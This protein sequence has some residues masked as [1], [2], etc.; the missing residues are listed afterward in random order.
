MIEKAF[1]E[2]F[3]NREFNYTTQLKYSRQFSAYNA[4]IRSHGKSLEVKMCA[5]W[6]DIGEEI[7]I[8]CIQHLLQ[9][10]FK[11]KQDTFYTKLYS[12]FIKNLADA[13]PKTLADP[14]LV[15]LFNT[16]NEEYFQND[17]QIPN[18]KWGTAS[19]RQLGLYNYQ[20]DTITISTLFK[21]HLDIAKYILYHELLHKQEKF[22]HKNGRSHHHTPRFRALEK[23]FKNQQ[24]MEDKIKQIIRNR[25][26][27]QPKKGLFKWF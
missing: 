21:E 12:D 20:T 8:G 10:L 7:Q 9:K 4:N 6:K 17:M 16:I 25:R 14:I 27:R 5:N 3:P 1:K 15:E 13:T 22:E 2:L 26:N 18:L 24:L 23:Q 19:Y 11:S